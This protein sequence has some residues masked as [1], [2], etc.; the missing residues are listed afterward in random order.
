MDL[1]Y[2]ADERAFR[3]E[4]RAF[5]AKSLPPGLAAKVHEGKRLSREDFL[6]WHR[7]L[8][9]QGWVASGWPK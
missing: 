6:L 5:V 2:T 7:I 3:D 1:E 8:A 9:E 4:V